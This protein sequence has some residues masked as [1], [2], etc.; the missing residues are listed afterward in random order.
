MWG[1]ERCCCTT[2]WGAERCVYNRMGSR[3]REREV[4]L[5]NRM[6]SR[7]RGAAATIEWGVEREVLLQ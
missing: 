1:A 3:E 4:L 7:E 6:R 5:Y 2:E